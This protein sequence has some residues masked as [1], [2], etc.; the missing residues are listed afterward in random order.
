MTH[1][2]SSIPW[3]GW[4]VIVFVVFCTVSVYMSDGEFGEYPPPEY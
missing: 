3:Y 4:A 2:L 1:L